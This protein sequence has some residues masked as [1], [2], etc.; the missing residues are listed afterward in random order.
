MSMPPRSPGR[1]LLL[2]AA[3]CLLLAACDHYAAAKGSASPQLTPTPGAR[4]DRPTGQ[5][6][7]AARPLADHGR[8]RAARRRF[9]RAI[10]PSVR[11][12]LRSLPARGRRDRRRQRCAALLG[13]VLRRARATAA[14]GGVPDG[15][16]RVRRRVSGSGE[17]GV[18]VG[19]GRR[20]HPP[21]ARDP[22]PEQA[23]RSDHGPDD[24]RLD[25]GRRAD[26]RGRVAADVDGHDRRVG[27]ARVRRR[28]RRRGVAAESRRG[29][30]RDRDRRE[31]RRSGGARRPTPSASSPRRETRTCS[32]G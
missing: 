29:R 4:A 13:W 14:A 24:R 16:H 10:G 28:R 1:L 11:L 7:R 2:L 3:L 32:C 25:P 5:L 20:R 18:P 31:R 19:A 23:E 8:A 26:G 9:V 12:S 15:R 27:R 17:P 6:C 30:R 21:V 22:Q